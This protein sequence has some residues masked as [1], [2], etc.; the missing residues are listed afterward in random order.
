MT[1]AEVVAELLKQPQDLD[2]YMTNGDLDPVPVG[3]VSVQAAA[4]G[5]LVLISQ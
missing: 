4:Y 1:V 3:S 2:A 5:Q